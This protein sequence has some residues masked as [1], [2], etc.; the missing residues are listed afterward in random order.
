MHAEL[1]QGIIWAFILRASKHTNHKSDA[2]QKHAFLL[3]KS[4]I[5]D[6]FRGTQ[7]LNF[8]F[9]KSNCIS[10][11]SKMSLFRFHFSV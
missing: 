7:H 10:L 5:W 11:V 6:S 3:Y 2:T 4:A 9:K 8:V 1:K